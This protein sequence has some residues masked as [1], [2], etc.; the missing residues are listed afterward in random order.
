[1]IIALVELV[2]VEHIPNLELF[3]E[4]WI[5]LF[6]RS[7]SKSVEGIS[8]QFWQSDWTQGFARRAIFDVARSRFPIQPKPLIRL[9][10]AMS[11]SGFLDTDPLSTSDSGGTEGEV[12]SEDRSVCA[13]CVVEYL[14]SMGS[15]TQVVPLSACTGS[16]AL[17]EKLP[18]RYNSASSSSGPATTCLSYV[19]LKAVRLPGG[20]TLPPRTVGRLLSSDAGEFVVIAWQYEHSGWK[21]LL[22]FLTDYVNRRRMSSGGVP[23]GASSYHD[24]SF[25]RSR[26]DPD[27]P[28]FQLEDIG[29][30]MEQPEGDEVLVTDILDLIRSVIQD[31]VS[32][33][34]RLLDSLESGDPVAAHSTSVST[35]PDLVQLTTMILEEALSRSAPQHHRKN[36]PRTPLITSAMS[37]LAA[38][39]AL[40][41]YS[42]R[43]WL[44]IRSTASLFGS[45]RNIGVTSNVL[46]AER[47][48]GHYTMTLALLNL[49][50]QLFLEASTSLLPVLQDNPKLQLVKEEVLMRAARFVHS[51]IWIEHTGWKYAQLGDRFEIGRRV[52]AFYVDILKHSPPSLSPTS[53][54]A[55]TGGGPF[56]KLSQTIAD[57]LL[58]RATLS[59]V[60]PIVSSITSANSILGMLYKGRRY[61]DARRL[62]YLLESHLLLARMLLNCKLQLSESASSATSGLTLLEASLCARGTGG[63]SILLFP[64]ASSKLDPIDALVALVKER[65]M[66]SI[67]PVEAMQVLFSLCASLAASGGGG[68]SGS[69][70]A[71]IVGHLS[72]PEGTVGSMV[73][74]VQHPYDEFE[75]RNAVWNFITLAVDKEP[76]LAGLFVTGHFRVPSIKGKEPERGGDKGKGKE[77]EKEDMGKMTSALGVAYNTLEQWKEYWETNPQLLASLLRFLD[78]VWEHGHEHKVALEPYRQDEAFF[79]Y[80]A[81]IVRE[82]LGPIPDDRT[83]HFHHSTSGGDPNVELNEAVQVHAYRTIVKAHALHIIGLDIGMALQSQGRTARDPVKP[84]SYTAIEG[85][86]KSEEQLTDFIGEAA[87]RTYDPSLHDD[88]QERSQ[89]FFPSLKLE[90]LQVQEPMVEREFGNDFSF[91][92][93]LLQVRLEP[94]TG[95]FGDECVEIAQLLAS[96]NL[97]LSLAHAQTTLTQSWQHFLIQVVPFLRGQATVRPI[98]LAIAASI[99][100]DIASEKRS[101]DMM[102]TV[103]NARLSLLLGLLEVAWFSTSDKPDEVKHFISLVKNLRGI[104]LNPSQPPAKSF[105]GKSSVPF[106]RSILQIAYFCARHCRTLINR[107]KALNAD[108]RL[109]I[110]STL[111]AT[112]DLVVDALRV[113]FD[114]ARIKLDLDLDQDM[115]LLVT[116]FEQCTRLDLNPSPVLWLT[117]CQETDVIRSSL[118]LISRTDLVGFS[119]LPLLRSRKQ[120]LYAPHVLMF[121]TALAGI[122]ASAERLASEGILAA[123]SENPISTAIKS[124]S[125]D[126]VLQEL[127]GER[128]PAHVSYCTM[129]AVVAG[130]ITALGR[131]GHYFHSDVCGLIQLFGD[132]IHRA[133]SWTIDDPLTLP[134]LEE[135][136]QIVHLFSGIAQSSASPGTT[137]VVKTALT[138]FSQDALLLLQ[139]INYALTHPN[140]LAS[141]FEPI[142]ASERTRFEADSKSNASLMSSPSEMIDPMRRPFLAR[143]VHRLFALSSSILSTLTSISDAE[144]VLTG[145]REDWPDSKILIV[146]VSYL[147]FHSHDRWNNLTN[148]ILVSIPKWYW[149]NLHRLEHFSRWAIAHWISCDS[150]SIDLHCKVSPLL[151]PTRRNLSMCE[152]A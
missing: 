141:V 122:T 72:D 23:G 103:H 79:G 26:Q 149:V 65:G 115:E 107:S 146:P 37:V 17:Y 112:L 76:A 58:G 119:D 69:P 124:G 113:A 19:N 41:K 68:G 81:A 82:E 139:Q 85:I 89:A 126:V 57:A 56:G 38:L 27:H 18:E 91:S 4:V 151:P 121:H 136:E 14:E 32:L 110:S 129:L 44:Y 132:Q 20:S 35:A 16:H 98:L 134:L 53:G 128:S 116:V 52:S 111:E 54:S 94:F 117:R 39:L 60:Y 48:T 3:I 150:W 1:M 114:S 138:S 148:H 92:L 62:V 137:D 140:H 71:T 51:E 47:L 12:V 33:A 86:F 106:H 50:Q 135:V 101:G 30:E 109:T 24:V 127:P 108:Q 105:L 55:G 78:V 40:P 147:T 96:I 49:V 66:G 84:I 9:L 102:S 2:P 61:G 11:A 97:N 74:I 100:A 87:S 6:G 28:T 21:V 120:P 118:Q 99:S 59:A 75:L 131:H 93:A 104:I 13:Q 34:Q 63:S 25:G 5:A 80:L 83:D 15:F 88:L 64:S 43:V 143:L 36:P 7:E 42:N 46:A 95:S 10:R 31:N 123:Y 70:A 67:V 29:V 8:R 73:R 145:E 22:E 125:I 152:I 144:T 142:T 133:L 77:K 90:H 45:E 130:V